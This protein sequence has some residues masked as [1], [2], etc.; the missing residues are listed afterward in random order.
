MCLH[1][2]CKACRR[3]GGG[4]G[5]FVLKRDCGDVGAEPQIIRH[6]RKALLSLLLESVLES[7]HNERNACK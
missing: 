3:D 6:N 2:L 5:G 1:Y 4:G 7:K